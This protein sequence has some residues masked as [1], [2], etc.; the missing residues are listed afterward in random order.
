MYIIP[1]NVAIN[2]NNNNIN[3]REVDHWE[4]GDDINDKLDWKVVYYNIT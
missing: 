1:W 3:V 2:N 4:K